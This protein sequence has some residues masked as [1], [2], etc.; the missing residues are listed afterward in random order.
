[1]KAPEHPPMSRPPLRS[2]LLVSVLGGG[3]LGTI[4]AAVCGYSGLAAT[5]YRASPRDEALLLAL[6][7]G[8]PYG[9]A[10]GFLG[11]LVLNGVQ[12]WRQRR[13]MRPPSNFVE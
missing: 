3:L 9:L 8:C 4:G 11:G 5:E 13:G 6:G 1:M 7:W 12:R 2:W 10:V